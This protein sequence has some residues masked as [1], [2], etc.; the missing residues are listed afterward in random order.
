MFMSMPK[1]RATRIEPGT[2]PSIRRGAAEGRPPHTVLVALVV[3]VDLASD[4]TALLRH[5]VNVRVRDAGADR[6]NKLAPL[7]GCDPLTVWAD[8]VRG[9]DRARI[10]RPRDARCWF[11]AATGEEG[12][13]ATGD[14]ALAEVNVSEQHVAVEVCEGQ[15]VVDGLTLLVDGRGELT[16]PGARDR[17]S[18][19]VAVE[20]RLE[21]ALVVR[22]DDARDGNRKDRE[23]EDRKHEQLDT[24][25]DTSPFFCWAVRNTR[26]SCPWI[27]T[28]ILQCDGRLPGCRCEARSPRVHGSPR[29]G[30]R[31]H[32]DPSGR[33]GE[34]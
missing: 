6:G 7:T 24:H 12:G 19:F 2:F 34:R 14:A 15:R 30:R 1:M 16:A 3:V 10:G 21:A 23:S 25:S 9:C 4:L 32:E 29:T 28:G 8:D 27:R 33:T 22:G 5:R 18:L 31:A 17:W 20:R 13:Y 11:A 26:D